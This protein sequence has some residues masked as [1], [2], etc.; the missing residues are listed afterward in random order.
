[1]SPISLKCAMTAVPVRFD[2][3][4][5][6][7]PHQFITDCSFRIQHFKQQKRAFS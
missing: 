3:E 4:V 2:S 1:M 5:A 6:T 7:L